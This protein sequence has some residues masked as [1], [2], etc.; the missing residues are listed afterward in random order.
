MPDQNDSKTANKPVEDH[1]LCRDVLPYKGWKVLVM[2]LDSALRRI[3]QDLPGAAVAVR[4]ARSVL[5]RTTP[6]S[7]YLAD[8]ESVNSHNTV[9]CS[10]C[11]C[12]CEAPSEKVDPPGVKQSGDRE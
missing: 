11:G 1:T 5:D 6:A 12:G 9:G 10:G 7:K 8:A 4:R 3:E 2:S